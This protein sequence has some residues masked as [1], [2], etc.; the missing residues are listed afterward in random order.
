MEKIEIAKRIGTTLEQVGDLWQGNYFKHCKHFNNS[1]LE[2]NSILKLNKTLI[3][4]NSLIYSGRLR[5]KRMSWKWLHILKNFEDLDAS[6]FKF[7]LFDTQIFTLFINWKK[8]ASWST[9]YNKTHFGH[10]VK[11]LLHTVSI[12]VKTTKIVKKTYIFPKNKYCT[13]ISFLSFVFLIT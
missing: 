13:F 5:D 6:G 3:K 7:C 11:C 10:S 4:V 9:R 12:V 1:L 2:V 8:P